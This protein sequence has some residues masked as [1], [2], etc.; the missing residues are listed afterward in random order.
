MVEAGSRDISHSI[1]RTA[2]PHILQK[3]EDSSDEPDWC[4]NKDAQF[5]ISTIIT[6]ISTLWV[7]KLSQEE[8]RFS[9]K[10]TLTPTNFKVLTSVIIV[11]MKIWASLSSH[12]SGSLK[13]QCKGCCPSCRKWNVFRACLHPHRRKMHIAQV[14]GLDHKQLMDSPPTWTIRKLSLSLIPRGPRW[15]A[16]V[17]QRPYFR[18]RAAQ[19]EAFRG[20]AAFHY[21]SCIP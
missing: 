17:V 6:L 9:L 18:P 3:K 20:H 4:D 10:K 1:G 12:Q 14:Q 21:W 16:H 15:L 2:Y 8:C 7:F 11:E 19:F 5:L 13:D